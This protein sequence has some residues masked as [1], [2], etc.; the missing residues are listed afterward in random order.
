MRR[1]RSRIY[2]TLQ[3]LCGTN[4]KVFCQYGFFFFSILSLKCQAEHRYIQKNNKNNNKDGD[5]TSHWAPPYSVVFL[6]SLPQSQLQITSFLT[7][8]SC[9]H[10]FL[11]SASFPPPQIRLFPALSLRFPEQ[12][13][14]HTSFLFPFNPHRHASVI[15]SAEINGFISMVSPWW[16]IMSLIII[17]P[18]WRIMSLIRIF[19]F[20]VYIFFLQR[21]SSMSKK[22]KT[23]VG[24]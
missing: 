1:W 17:S 9:L 18:G 16:W 22:A 6:T 5:V 3:K 2:L 13:T 10:H 21:W 15:R 12:H 11:L 4:R 19:L 14:A 8:S 23:H 24:D 7:S 20:F